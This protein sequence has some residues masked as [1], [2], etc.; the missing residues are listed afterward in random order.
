M[1]A[2]FKLRPQIAWAFSKGEMGYLLIGHRDP[3]IP[4]KMHEKFN[5]AFVTSVDTAENLAALIAE[6]IQGVKDI[7]LDLQDAHKVFYE[8][9]LRLLRDGK[10]EGRPRDEY[11]FWINSLNQIQKAKEAQWRIL[12]CWI[13]Y[14]RANIRL[15]EDELKLIDVKEYALE[16]QAQL[17]KRK[18]EL[19]EKVFQDIITELRKKCKAED[20]SCIAEEANRN[21][22]NPGKG[23]K[24][25]SETDRMKVLKI[26][27]YRSR[28]WV[29]RRLAENVKYAKERQGCWEGGY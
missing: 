7:L 1:N 4:V 18:K 26:L 28:P 16:A 11:R 13:Q 15:W 19:K 27:D 22:K 17:P 6:F 12:N 9:S 29:E 23:T 8:Y 10:T 3:S 2:E 24:W 20:R 21:R 14:Y 25:G 5:K